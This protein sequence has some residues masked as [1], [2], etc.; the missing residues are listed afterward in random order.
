MTDITLPPIIVT[1]EPPL[2]LP[3]GPLPGGG[4]IAKPLPWDGKIVDFSDIDA[5]M[6]K[7]NFSHPDSTMTKV[8]LAVRAQKQIA[9]SYAANLP[10]LLAEIDSEVAAAVGA[11]ALSALEKSRKEKAV[12]DALINTSQADLTASL[13]AA[14]AYFGRDPL[15]KDIPHN[16]VDFV[17]LEYKDRLGFK[18]A[19]QALADSYSAAYKSRYLSEKIRLLTEKSNALTGLIAT[20]QAEED[21]RLAAQAEAER[22][23]AEAAAKAEAERL[24]EEQAK[25]A[26]QIKDAIKFTADFYKEIGGKFGQQMSTLSAELAESAK[27]KKLRSAQ[28]ALNAFEQYKGALDKKFSAADRAAIVNALDSLDSAELGKNL[29]RFAKGFGYVGKAVDA[30]DLH[31]EVSKSYAT[32][33]WNNTALK[34]ETLFAGAAATGLIAFAFGVTVS[35]PVGIVAFALIMAFVSAFIDDKRVK[36]FNDALDAVLPF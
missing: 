20:A 6:R 31:N 10:N 5:L 13:A 11:D 23:A 15:L 27:G 36:Q 19:Y 4:F 14:N 2:P 26:A 21:A 7:M 8:A 16:A 25:A 18:H 12:V 3:P 9:D 35:S 34:V 32:G 28:E 22:L 24:A 17:N 1:P 29:N 33:D 30:Y